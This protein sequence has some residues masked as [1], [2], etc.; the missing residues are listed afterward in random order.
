[1][2]DD[3]DGDG[4][5]N[6]LDPDANDDNN[7]DGTTPTGDD[8]GDGVPNYL[9]VYPGGPDNERVIPD[10]DGDGVADDLRAIGGGA[11]RGCSCT[12]TGGVFWFAM[13]GLA[14]LRRKRVI[15]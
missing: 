1:D 12:T 8:D 2:N 15:K 14:F 9:D 7:D 5:V 6:W 4:I 11:V 3:A 13:L 10:V